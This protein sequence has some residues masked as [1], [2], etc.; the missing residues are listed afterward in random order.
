MRIFFTVLILAFFCP[1]AMLMAQDNK[2]TDATWRD[3]EYLDKYYFKSYKTA[4]YTKRKLEE[5]KKRMLRDCVEDLALKIMSDI[6]VVQEN[7]VMEREE[8]ISSVFTGKTSVSSNLQVTGMRTFFYTEKR[9]KLNHAFVYIS[10]RDL[11]TVYIHKARMSLK[12]FDGQLARLKVLWDSYEEQQGKDE[13]R[14]IRAKVADILAAMDEGFVKLNTY[15]E[16]VAVA[17]EKFPADVPAN[18]LRIKAEKQQFQTDFFPK[19]LTSSFAEANEAMAKREYGKA[20]SLYQTIL[21]E[22]PHSEQAT[23][24]LE[25]AKRAYAE[26]LLVKAEGALRS[27]KYAE[28]SEYVNE[29]LEHQPGNRASSLRKRIER[30]YFDRLAKSLEKSLEVDDLVNA[31]RYFAELE[32]YWQADSDRFRVLSN[33]IARLRNT[34]DTNRKQTDYDRHISSAEVALSQKEFV[35]AYEYVE[36]AESLIAGKDR[37]E[38]LRNRIQRSYYRHNKKKELKR[39]P[40][41]YVFTLGAGAFTHLF[42]TASL[43]IDT[44]SRNSWSPMVSGGFF[45]RVNTQPK[46]IGGRDFSKA[47]LLGVFVDAG[48]FKVNLKDQTLN[49]TVLKKNYYYHIEAGAHFWEAVRVSGGILKGISDEE[50]YNYLSGTFGL[51]LKIRHFSV[52]VDYTQLYRLEEKEWLGDN[53]ENFQSMLRIG[54]QYQLNFYRR[55]SKTEKERIRL[56]SE[57]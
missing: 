14:G 49:E 32:K 1:G 7:T 46:F 38:N 54:L 20:V 26:E 19:D 44:I 18:V 56:S 2:W 6:S 5:D 24:G 34:T 25:K 15:E 22:R 21:Y 17:G 4:K 39:T 8:L 41:K 51:A 12:D 55:L 9:K 3:G 52:Q 13:R 30:A 43:T 27:G 16:V 33:R 11:A 47:T 10:K 48:S 35:K 36:G 40:H 42:K 28:A 37:A 45:R 57:L 31:E 53:E 50:N 29:S 23:E